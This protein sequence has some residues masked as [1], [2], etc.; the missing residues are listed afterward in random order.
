MS[1]HPKT[2]PDYTARFYAWLE[3]R[4]MAD[5]QRT[6]EAARAYLA[7]IVELLGM[8]GK[9]LPYDTERYGAA[10]GA[11][12]EWTD[13]E[14]RN[15]LRLRARWQRRAVGDDRRW[16]ERGEKPGRGEPMT[17]AWDAEPLQPGEVPPPTKGH[18]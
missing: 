17:A 8:D 3:E 6:P 16:T 2:K 9:R 11:W 13:N 15:L 7:R 14:K 10:A 5:G 12:I 1:P 18:R 4:P